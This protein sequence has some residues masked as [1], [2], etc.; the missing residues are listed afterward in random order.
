MPVAQS[1][2]ALWNPQVGQRLILDLRLSTIGYPELSGRPCLILP[3][4]AKAGIPVQTGSDLTIGSL[5]H[6]F[7]SAFVRSGGE[8]EVD[9]M[10]RPGWL[11]RYWHRHE[12]SLSLKLQIQL[13]PFDWKLLEPMLV[14][15]DCICDK[16]T[17]ADYLRR[18]LPERAIALYRD[19]V[20]DILDLHF[21]NPAAGYWRRAP[22]PVLE[23][24]SA[25]YRTGRLREAFEAIRMY[26]SFDDQLGLPKE[27]RQALAGLKRD[28][29]RAIVLRDGAAAL[30]QLRG[31]PLSALR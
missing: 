15:T 25:L 26:E 13:Q 3:E 27:S 12:T 7:L 22:Y 31:N 6:D 23:L 20:S 8:T 1:S 14:A 21:D 9:I 11:G 2:A 16:I 5:K 10:N 30:R 24:A 17:E 18:K 4:R 19:A 28:L 29:S